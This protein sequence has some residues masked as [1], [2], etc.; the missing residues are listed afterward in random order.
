MK[1]RERE[2]ERKGVWHHYRWLH[3][4]YAENEEKCERRQESSLSITKDNQ[5][6]KECVSIIV[7]QSQGRNQRC[8]RNTCGGVS[9][10]REGFA[11]S[12]RTCQCVCVS[13]SLLLCT[14]TMLRDGRRD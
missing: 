13:L 1:K 12:D 3:M 8:M 14:Y 9:D 6:N 2:R 4:H 7:S 10:A 5:L 11:N